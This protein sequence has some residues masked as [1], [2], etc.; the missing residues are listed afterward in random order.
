MARGGAAGVLDRLDREV[1]GVRALA[2]E[3]DLVPE[4]ENQNPKSR[5]VNRFIKLAYGCSMF[6]LS[7]DNSRDRYIKGS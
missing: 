4:D 1:P 3:I 2:C 5:D 6:H 7:G